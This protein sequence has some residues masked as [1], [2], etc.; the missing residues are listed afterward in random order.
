MSCDELYSDK[1]LRHWMNLRGMREPQLLFA[2]Y[3]LRG[4]GIVDLT[5]NKHGKI[6]KIKL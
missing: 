1:E 4:E 5:N 3:D 2:L 6:I